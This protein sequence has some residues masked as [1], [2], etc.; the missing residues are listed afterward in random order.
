MHRLPQIYRVLLLAGLGVLPLLLLVLVVTSDMAHDAWF[1][2]V[3]L[4]IPLFSG[5]ALY[6]IRR[7]RQD[8]A[9]EE[10]RRNPPG[11]SR[12]APDHTPVYSVLISVTLPSSSVELLRVARAL[13]PPE[14]LRVTALHMWPEDEFRAEAFAQ[15][16]AHEAPE[17]LR[18][19]LEAAGG[20]Q[21]EPLCLVSADMGADITAVAQEHQADLVL[22]NWHEPVSP[23]RN[24]PGLVQAALR[25]T[26]SDVAVYLAR[27]FRPYRR[28][29]VPY[30]GGTHDRAALGLV[31]RLGLHGGV[32]V[33]ILHVVPPG[34]KANEPRM[35]L[36]RIV[37]DFRADRVRLKVVEHEDLVE[38]A[39]HEAWMGYD[40]IVAG[41]SEETGKEPALFA[42]R[43]E[44][45]AFATSA[46]ILVVRG[47]RSARPARDLKGHLTDAAT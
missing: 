6:H 34:R 4:L 14:Q 12:P 42:A 47:R 45:L 17:P 28:V 10:S 26:S 25:H 46:S 31:R 29:L 9:A 20:L 38:A 32:K 5:A 41:A 40:L 3:V 36:A 39:V 22:L 19:L 16:D 43:H 7:D 13:A 18:P 2:L 23:S 33:T 15:R 35:G 44:R 24:L 1:Y 37:E 11:S 30:A 8:R 27:H 21:V